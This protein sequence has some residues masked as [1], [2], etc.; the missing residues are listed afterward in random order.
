MKG[1]QAEQWI[2]LK[3]GTLFFH[4]YFLFIRNLAAKVSR[5]RLRSRLRTKQISHVK[6]SDLRNI[7]VSHSVCTVA[8]S[9]FLN[10]LWVVWHGAT[11]SNW[12]MRKPDI[13]KTKQ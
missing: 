9:D 7:F 5:S 12:A 8:T 10:K 1:R 11:I 6:V 4:T 2:L 13:L 3:N